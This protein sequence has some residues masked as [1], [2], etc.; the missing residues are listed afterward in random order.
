MTT[1]KTSDDNRWRIDKHVPLALVY[2]LVAQFLG[3]TWMAAQVL[4]KIESQ[5]RRITVIEAQRVGE[6]LVSLE[7]QVADTKSLLQR[8][9]ANL[10]RLIE[11]GSNK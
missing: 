7:S 3:A 5:E 10:L 1:P 2:L 4:G 11:R 9:D 8:V 6:R